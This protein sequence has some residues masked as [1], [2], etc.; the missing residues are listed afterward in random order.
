SPPS[1]RF[2]LLGRPRFRGSRQPSFLPVVFSQFSSPNGR[3]SRIHRSNASSSAAV[4]GR[5]TH[6]R[7][8][9]LASAGCFSSVSR[10]SAFSESCPALL[11]GQCSL[12]VARPARTAFL[13]TYRQTV[14]KCGPSCIAKL[15]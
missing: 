12:A 2:F 15:L 8:S 3:L 11:Q 5:F 6:S 4:C 13:S 10:N 7:Q 9:A 1:P 14:V